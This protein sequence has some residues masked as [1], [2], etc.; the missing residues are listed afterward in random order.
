[1]GSR[2][3]LSYNPELLFVKKTFEKICPYCKA[4][5]DWKIVC[6]PCG[7]T[8]YCSDEHQQA[9]MLRHSASCRAAAT[10]PLTVFLEIDS[11]PLR[12]NH[13]GFVDRA[14]PTKVRSHLFAR[15][16]DAMEQLK[17]FSSCKTIK[18]HR[19]P[20]AEL[21]GWELE[22]Y[23]DC[24]IVPEENP[25]GALLYD[26]SIPQNIPA[27]ILTSPLDRNVYCDDINRKESRVF[28]GSVFLTGRHC[29][30][31]EL[32]SFDDLF[33][34]LMFIKDTSMAYHTNVSVYSDK[35]VVPE[36][37]SEVQRYATWGLSIME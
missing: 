17:K 34:I 18:T 23:C 28:Y 2:S 31:G 15:K 35:T 4:A 6:V 32:L 7:E 25:F 26:N 33:S 16:D 29:K 8:A 3:I 1:M 36:I 11:S 9:D 14:V 20:F 37:V 13:G 27:S 19:S 10:N 21:L 5:G 22:I 12:S 30:T 24:S